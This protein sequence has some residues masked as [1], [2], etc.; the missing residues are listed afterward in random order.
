MPRKSF[1]FQGFA[2]V[3]IVV[4]SFGSV[5]PVIAVSVTAAPGVVFVQGGNNAEKRTGDTSKALKGGLTTGIASVS[6][7]SV[8]RVPA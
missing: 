4:R 8:L 1:S 7:A 6:I 5:V 3:Q 2:G